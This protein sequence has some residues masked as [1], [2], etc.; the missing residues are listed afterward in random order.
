[1]FVIILTF[2]LQT[3]IIIFRS[4]TFTRETSADMTVVEISVDLSLSVVLDLNQANNVR[5]PTHA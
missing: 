3:K 1:M 4:V 2:W 5:K